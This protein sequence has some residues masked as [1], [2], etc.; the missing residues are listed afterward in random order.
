MQSGKRGGGVNWVTNLRAR[1][2]HQP[3]VVDVMNDYTLV[4]IQAYFLNK[5]RVIIPVFFSR[6]LICAKFEIII[7]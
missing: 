4:A 7:R 2:D 5:Y 6:S 1:E 3:F